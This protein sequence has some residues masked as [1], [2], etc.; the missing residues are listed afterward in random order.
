MTA[1]LKR[2]NLGNSAPARV[3][4][5]PREFAAEVDTRILDAA[6]TL[7]LENG[8][9]GTSIDEVARLARAGKPT[10]YAR[11]ASKEVLFT[12]VAMNNADRVIGGFE[13]HVPTGKTADER[14]VNLATTLLRQVLVGQTVDFMRLAIGEA[15]RF[16]DLASHIH[17]LALERAA[18][19]VATLLGEASQGDKA[20]DAAAFTPPRLN[21]T[22]R[23]FLNLTV[24]PLILRALFGES[25]ESLQD[26]IGPHVARG[27]DFFL[28]GCRNSG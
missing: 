2:G 7:F 10:I 26:E 20:M 9:A 3:G 21:D 28:A 5:P 6:R 27:V 8:L 4:R 22:A 16:P 15:R 17:R 13:G 19:T 25:L 24:T 11:F 1:K 14:L 12:A 18:E 23:T